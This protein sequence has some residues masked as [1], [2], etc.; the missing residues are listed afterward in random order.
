MVF[1]SKGSFFVL[2]FL[3]PP[4]FLTISLHFSDDFPTFHDFPLINSPFF[5]YTLSS[6]ICMSGWAWRR[7]YFFFSFL[8][9]SFFLSSSLLSFL[10]LRLKKPACMDAHH[11][12]CIHGKIDETHDGKE[13]HTRVRLTRGYVHFYYPFFSFSILSFFSFY[14]F[15]LSFIFLHFEHLPLHDHFFRVSV[16]HGCHGDL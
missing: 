9:A 6:F 8:L 1:F 4:P 5:Y 10:S 16:L 14:H 3:I 15:C 11:D 2:G 12:H 13:T 7:M